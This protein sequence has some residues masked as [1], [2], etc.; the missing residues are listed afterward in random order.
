MSDMTT[1]FE[2]G[3]CAQHPDQESM[4]DMEIFRQ[5]QIASSADSGSGGGSS[6]PLS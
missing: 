4:N 5:T 6:K 1:I 2:I 3:D